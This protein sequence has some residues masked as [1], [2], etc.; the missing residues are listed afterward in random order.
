M[1]TTGRW[2]RRPA[3]LAILATLLLGSLLAAPPAAYAAPPTNDDIAAAVPVTA[4]PFVAEVDTS[5]A[6]AVR[7]DGECVGGSSVWYRFRPTTTQRL[8]AVTLGSDYDTFLAVFE[9]RRDA[10]RLVGCSDDLVNLA[11]GL[12]MRFRAERRYWFAVSSCCSRQTPIPGGNAVLSLYRP[13]PVGLSVSVD[14]VESGG[15]SGRLLVNG[16]VDCPT[17]SLVGMRLRASQRLDD[18][19]AR[20][21]VRFEIDG[22]RSGGTTWQARINSRTGWAFRP[23][24]VILDADT[25]VLDGFA[26]DESTFETTATVVENPTAR[27]AP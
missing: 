19:V 25:F 20:G 11:S 27:P 12:E 17:P 23:G 8:R 21:S 13:E 24:S 10:R 16:T 26:F 7:S 18:V 3:A 9:G 1:N 15:I 14:S 6:T 5:E 4:L 22:C 2:T